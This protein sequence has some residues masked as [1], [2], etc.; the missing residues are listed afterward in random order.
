MKVL[1]TSSIEMLGC[2]VHY[3][4]RHGLYFVMENKCDAFIQAFSKWGWKVDTWPTTD[5]IEDVIGRFVAHRVTPEVV[6]QSGAQNLPADISDLLVA[7]IRKAILR[8]MVGHW[9]AWDGLAETL[10]SLQTPLRVQTFGTLINTFRTALLRWAYRSIIPN[11]RV[12]KETKL[13]VNI[14]VDLLYYEAHN[15]LDAFKNKLSSILELLEIQEEDLT[16]TQIRIDRRQGVVTWTSLSEIGRRCSR[17]FPPKRPLD[18]IAIAVSACTPALD[19]KT[20]D[21]A[22]KKA[23]EYIKQDSLAKILLT[24]LSFTRTGFDRQALMRIS[25]LVME[26]VKPC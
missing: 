9:A 18:A 4:T 22:F 3:D 25:N 23:I 5:K 24:A 11:P 2:T 26:E 10:R 7:N 1:L 13:F 19:P 8:G 14:Y 21:D 20:D 12:D 15:F 6:S 17:N 16:C